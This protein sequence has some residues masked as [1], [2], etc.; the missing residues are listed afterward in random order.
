MAAP[1]N[2]A[3]LYGTTPATGGYNALVQA[4]TSLLLGVNTT[5]TTAISSTG[6]QTVTPAAM[7]NIGVGTAVWINYNSSDQECVSVT[8]VTGSTFTANFTRT[9]SANM[10]VTSGLPQLGV[11]SPWTSATVPTGFTTYGISKIFISN[12]NSAAG[13]YSYIPVILGT[14]TPS[15][16]PITGMALGVAD[17][18]DTAGN[19]Y[20][21]FPGNGTTNGNYTGIFFSAA[22]LPIQ[23]TT[24][25]WW[26]FC[27]EY[28]VGIV[29][30]ISTNYNS[31]YAGGLRTPAPLQSNGVTT[32]TTALTASGSNV[33]IPLAVD[34]TSNLTAGQNIAIINQSHSHTSSHFGNAE[35]QTVV[36]FVSGAS[37]TV[38]VTSLTN[39]Y[40]TGA[41][42]GNMPPIG[43]SSSGSNTGFSSALYMTRNN[44]VTWASGTGQ[45]GTVDTTTITSGI[46]NYSSPTGT[47]NINKALYG[48]EIDPPFYQTTTAYEGITGFMIGVQLFAGANVANLDY[49]TDLPLVWKAMLGSSFSAG[50]GPLVNAQNTATTVGWV[51]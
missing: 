1:P 3:Y 28:S 51:P 17:D 43:V 38:T 41:A 29:A 44:N 32:A 4:I 27:T 47:S 11:T 31:C 19:A 24:F 8:A 33:T 21:Q 23:D 40:D 42:I 2:I 12:Q 6:S 50:I 22:N 49:F 26:A 39:S 45:S 48:G 36:S 16:S 46:E 13:M 9:H 30:L 20:V 37:P 7:T 15:A 34:I 18:I 35:L 5:I 14:T 10:A 25:S